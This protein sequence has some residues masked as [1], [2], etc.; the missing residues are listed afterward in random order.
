MNKK[1][2]GAGLREHQAT[3]RRLSWR[4]PRQ[5]VAGTLTTR[6]GRQIM[7]A[8]IRV[9]HGRKRVRALL[10][11]ELVADT[12]APLLVWEV[13]FYPTYNIPVSDGRAELIPARTDQD[14]HLRKAA[15]LA[16]QVAV[17]PLAECAA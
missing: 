13:P 4:E 11:G 1:L 9:E 3:C 6:R 7:T 14:P 5:P 8:E 17:A 16:G 2:P 15:G 12:I 10:D